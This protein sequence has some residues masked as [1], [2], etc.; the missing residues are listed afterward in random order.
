MKSKRDDVRIC[1][2]KHQKRIKK[3]SLSQSFERIEER[4]RVSYTYSFLI[5]LYTRL[6]SLVARARVRVI[7]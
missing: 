5:R 3:E 4:S 6:I 7:T 1:Q 2:T